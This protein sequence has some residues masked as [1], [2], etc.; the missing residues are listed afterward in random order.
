MF[1]FLSAKLLGTPTEATYRAASLVEILHTATLVHDDVVDD[2]LERRGFFP[3]MR[4]G[5]IRH[6]YWW[7]I[8]FWLKVSSSLSKTTITE[9]FTF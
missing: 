2:S 5:K 9:F 1:V 8:T 3:Y 6:Q 4:F 7:E